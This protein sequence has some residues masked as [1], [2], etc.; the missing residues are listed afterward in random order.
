MAY[1]EGSAGPHAVT[2]AVSGQLSAISMTYAANG[3]LIE[4]AV[5]RG[6]STVD[7]AAQ[8]FSYDAENRLVEVKT[9]PDASVE[10]T[11]H[12]GWNFFSLPVIPEDGA[13]VVLLPSFAQDFEQLAKF[14]PAAGSFSHYVG[15]P[16]FD[17]FT[18]FE[19]GEGYQVYCKAT[20][21]VTVTF[22]GRLPTESASQTVAG[23]WD[24]LGAGVLT[25]TAVASWLTGV[26]YTDVRGHSPVDDSLPV[27]T[28][29]AVGK[30]YW[31]QAS[32]AATWTPPLPRDPTTRFVFDGDG[33]RVKRITDSQTTLYLGESYEQVVGG[34]ATKYVFAGSLRIA[35]V[36]QSPE[37][38][39]PS[40]LRF[41][42]TDH[43]GSSNVLT[44]ATG[45][46]VSLT[47]HTHYGSVAFASSLE[48]PASSPHIGFTGQRQ[49]TTNGLVL[50]PARAYD[51]ELGRFLQADPFVHDP[52]D[53]QTLNRYSYVR[54]NP[55]R[56]VDPSG[57]T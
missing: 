39:A 26:S 17:D 21:P 40:Q 30:A 23:G 10:V 36:A 45:Q 54:N 46:L 14:D 49:D 33:G 15:N 7:L 27:A 3:N 16:T 5:A 28:Q 51:P 31:V 44:D 32:S 13:V 52:G 25:D 12:P 55:M 22:T 2:S 43:L 57:L 8:H 47:E 38:G 4:K 34:E 20:R 1:G 24:L 18:E 9:A 37:P 42:H 53:S 48:P 11:F 41:Y 6:L 29:A 35:S 56:Y 50:F 19:Y